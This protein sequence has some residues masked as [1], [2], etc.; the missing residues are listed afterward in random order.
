[1]TVL[2]GAV[3]FAV[4]FGTQQLLFS[5]PQWTNRDLHKILDAVPVALATIF[6]S[7]VA[8]GTSVVLVG[9][10][11]RANTKLERRRTELLEELETKKNALAADLEA[12]KSALAEQLDK[13]REELA[14]KRAEI[15]RKLNLFTEAREFVSSY[16][17]A[18]GELRIS[19]Y[20]AEEFR[21]LE[22]TMA[23]LRDALERDSSHELYIAWYDF[24][25]KG[26]NLCERAQTLKTLTNRW[27]LWAEKSEETGLPLGVEFGN[28]AQRVLTLLTAEREQVRRSALE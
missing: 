27:S 12:H 16:R 14:F 6:A 21:P 5:N 7:L 9:L 11:S 1:V 28:V 10:Q 13:N 23:K 19:G 8:A 15:E 25:Q 18:I 20:R 3:G 2:V 4:Y 24:H 26:F 17:Y 22:Q